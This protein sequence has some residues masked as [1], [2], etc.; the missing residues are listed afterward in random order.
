MRLKS[1]KYIPCCG[2]SGDHTGVAYE[3]LVVRC[4]YQ[5]QTVTGDLNGVIVQSRFT[6]MTS[7][8]SI[9]RSD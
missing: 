1:L 4:S 7:H 9:N 3:P 2:E 5:F 8:P 6:N